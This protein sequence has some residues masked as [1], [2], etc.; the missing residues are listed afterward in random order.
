M[1]IKL[2][3]MCIY[4]EIES[5]EWHV[6][7][8]PVATAVCTYIFARRE[9]RKR[10]LP[11]SQISLSQPHGMRR[12]RHAIHYR[13]SSVVCS[14][15][16]AIPSF[17]IHAEEN[18]WKRKTILFFVFYST[19]GILDT[20][21]HLLCSL[22]DTFH[23]GRS[24]EMVNGS[25]HMAYSIWVRCRVVGCCLCSAAGRRTALVAG[26][27]DEENG[28]YSEFFVRRGGGGNLN[29]VIV[30]TIDWINEQQ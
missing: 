9:K 4:I 3:S 21:I 30:N 5:G 1:N 25:N 28:K 15:V 27:M 14:A 7:R 11:S 26:T 24:C 22:Q 16:F 10:L 6:N 19:E 17:H 18:Q 23:S 20:H 2:H 12:C 8:C 29:W 13:V